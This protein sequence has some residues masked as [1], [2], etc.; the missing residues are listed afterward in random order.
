[1]EK[2]LILLAGPPATGKSYLSSLIC[3]A[4]PQTYTISPDEFKQDLADRVGF[5]TAEEKKELEQQVW[6]LYY[7]AL[8][9]YMSVGKQFIVTE[10][11]FS[12]KQKPYFEEFSQKYNYHII[13]IRLVAEFEVLWQ[14]RIQR[15]LDESRHLSF[16]MSHY[17]YGDA[18]QDRK[19]ADELI[20]KQGFWDIIEARQYNQFSLGKL[21]EIDVTDYATVDYAPLLEELVAL[22]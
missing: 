4:L 10:Y 16:L 14:R 6:H 20:T 8:E 1:M 21:Y 12:Y 11:P 2:Y 13:T 7:Q 22:S 15:D 3:D 19:Q 5:S 9:I 17:H 18:L